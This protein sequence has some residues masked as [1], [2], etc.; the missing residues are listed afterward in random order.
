MMHVGD[1][2]APPEIFL[3]FTRSEVASGVP[4]RLENSN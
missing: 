4:K 2:H 3:K 1:L